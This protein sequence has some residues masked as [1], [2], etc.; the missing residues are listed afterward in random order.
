MG[1]YSPAPTS[2]NHDC[3][4]GTAGSR[5]NRDNYEGIEIAMSHTVMI[6]YM[7]DRMYVVS[8][9]CI[10]VVPTY[11]SSVYLQV[12]MYVGGQWVTER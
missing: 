2:S 12:Y 8:G 1:G 5:V 7:Y 10:Q 3:A 9:S 4:L 6:I 11:S